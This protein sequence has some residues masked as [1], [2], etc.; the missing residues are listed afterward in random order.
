MDVAGIGRW[1][2]VKFLNWVWVKFGD[3]KVS[4]GCFCCCC[5]REQIVPDGK[6]K[7]IDFPSDVLPTRP[8]IYLLIYVTIWSP[9]NIKTLIS[10]KS[11]YPIKLDW[12][13]RDLGRWIHV[14]TFHPDFEW[15]GWYMFLC[16]VECLHF[17]RSGVPLSLMYVHSHLHLISVS[18]FPFMFS[19]GTLILDGKICVLV[20]I[21]S[22]D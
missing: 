5:W 9:I 20:V 8:P 7:D 10:L 11:S 18:A 2:W 22:S 21:R 4:C 19:I 13:R 6:L 12:A 1:V 16:W 14:I 3:G 15:P 17:Y